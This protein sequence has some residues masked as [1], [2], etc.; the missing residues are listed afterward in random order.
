MSKTL[1]QRFGG[2]WKFL[3]N[4]SFNDCMEYDSKVMFLKET[5][6]WI[7]PPHGS[8]YGFPMPYLNDDGTEPKNVILW[9]ISKG[10]P[11]KTI[12]EFGED[13]VVGCQERPRFE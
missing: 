6:T 13:F 5:I 1:S 4:I 12:L 9:L 8:R 11:T 7:D 10:Y 3:H 2:E